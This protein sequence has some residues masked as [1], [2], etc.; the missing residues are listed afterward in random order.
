MKNLRSL[1]LIFS[2]SFFNLLLTG[3]IKD[4]IT[5]NIKGHRVYLFEKFP[6]L[7]GK[8]PH[9]CL[10]DLPTPI[11][12]I[13]TFGNAVGCKNIYMKAD[14]LAGK[15]LSP[16]L[17]LEYGFTHLYGGNKPRKLEFLLADAASKAKDT[18][19]T[20]GCA[21]SN[22]ALATA[23]Y[24]K[25]L[26]F[27]NCILMLKNQPNSQ[28]VRHNL[29]LDY[30]YGALLQFYKNNQAR[31]VASKSITDNDQKAYFIPTGGS[32]EIGALGFVEAAFE[33]KEQI[34]QGKL[35]EPDLIYVPAGSFGTI[36]GLLF[37]MQLVGLSSKLVAVAVEPEEIENE[38]YVITKKLFKKINVLLNSFDKTVG[39]IEFP[40]EKLIINKNFA[41][42]EYGLFTSQAVNA[43]KIFKDTENIKIEGTYSSR[44]VA[45]IVEDAAN[46]LLFDKKVLL[47]N[48]FCSIDYSLLTKNISYKDLPVEFHRYFEEDF[49]PLAR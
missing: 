24:A 48:T 25:E 47:W 43:I 49:Q 38:I 18:I 33:L 41:G 19:I 6:D 23:V 11:I 13:E 10:C 17:A 32:N 36:A 14:Y 35:P 42:Q 12:K 45:A 2:L 46:G 20:Y 44:A 7:V 37:G 29:L 8:I 22:H 39:Q 26:G 27:K 30:Y 1:L 15:K 31:G 3:H 34:M 9:T 16:E 4:Q 21:G 40:E 5:D 28:V